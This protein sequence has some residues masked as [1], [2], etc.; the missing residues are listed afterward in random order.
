M[1]ACGDVAEND[2]FEV[3]AGDAV[4]VKEYVEAVG[5]EIL[6]DGEGPGHVGASVADEDGF[7]DALHWLVSQ[8]LIGSMR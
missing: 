5:L 4:V 7:L 1:G 3:A 2:L 6:E 8:F